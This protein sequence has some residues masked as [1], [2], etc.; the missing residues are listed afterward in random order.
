MKKIILAACAAA[1]ILTACGRP[2]PAAGS[3]Y[4]AWT[5]DGVHLIMSD[6]G[7]SDPSDDI[8]IDYEDNRV[9]SVNVI[10]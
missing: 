1:V 10:D 9:F 7:T 8:V 4:S 6:V 2:D 5:D 3:T